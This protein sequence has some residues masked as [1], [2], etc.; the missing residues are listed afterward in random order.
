MYLATLLIVF[1]AFQSK[2]QTAAYLF[3]NT[4]AYMLLTRIQYLFSIFSFLWTYNEM[5][6]LEG[7][8]Q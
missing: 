3:L 5:H 6:N 2:S 4:S 8:I 7:I 1:D